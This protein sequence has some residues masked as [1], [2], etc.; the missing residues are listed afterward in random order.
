VGIRCADHTTPLYLQKSTLTSPTSGGR[1]VGVG[2]SRTQA[3]EFF[4]PL[5]RCLGLFL[6]MYVPQAEDHRHRQPNASSSK[7]S[8][9]CRFPFVSCFKIKT[10][11]SLSSS[12]DVEECVGVAV[13]LTPALVSGPWRTAIH[14]VAV[15]LDV[16]GI[17]CA[18][19]RAEL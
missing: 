15:G 8:P 2:Y 1:S 14:E 16:S 17:R 6:G 19:A 11:S 7:G 9:I 18:G 10:E 12:P 5:R 3:K 4:V 13:V